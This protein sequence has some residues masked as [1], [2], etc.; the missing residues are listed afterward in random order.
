MLQVANSYHLPKD[1]KNNPR[2]V[3]IGRGSP[4]GNPYP[5]STERSR[6]EVIAMYENYLH[7]YLL[8][9]DRAIEA[10]NSIA[11]ML[12]DCSNQP[13]KLVCFCSPKACH[14]DL[15]QRLITDKLKEI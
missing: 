1:W 7:T 6:E 4:L 5:I 9:N 11:T 15:L 12:T 13:V 2:N 8:K 10:L 3:Y 14:G